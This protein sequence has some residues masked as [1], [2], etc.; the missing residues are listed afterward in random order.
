[1]SKSEGQAPPWLRIK[2]V[3]FWHWYGRRDAF[4]VVH[5][6]NVLKKIQKTVSNAFFVPILA[7]LKNFMTADI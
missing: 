1:M 3:T 5:A 4:R 6:P 7:Q 2:I